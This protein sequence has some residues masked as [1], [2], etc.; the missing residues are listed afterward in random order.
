[1]PE[2]PARPSAF[3]VLGFAAYLACSWTW[4]IGM[5]LPVVL[6]RDFGVWS[7]AVFAAPNIL[8]AAMMGSLL[9]RPGLS[10]AIVQRHPVVLRL[11][12]LVTLA[13]QWYFFGWQ[14]EFPDRP[15]WILWFLVAAVVMLMLL[16]RARDGDN[17]T[18]AV[19][20]LVWLASVGCMVAFL[21]ATR[22]IEPGAAPTDDSRG[23]VALAP[24]CVFGFALCPYLDLTFH[25]AR[26]Q[27]PGRAGSLAFALGFGVLFAVMI[28]FTVLYGLDM[29]RLDPSGRSVLARAP[30]V[31][32]ILL[33]LAFTIRLHAAWL[34]APGPGFA[35]LTRAA[36]IHALLVGIGL[37]YGARMPGD[38]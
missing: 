37:A 12:S 31:I 30:V 32:H 24:V 3:R 5:Y 25:Q 19:S 10:E 33:Q 27:L 23:L 2:G 4:C 13:F 20:L 34:N 6:L 21:F 18:L 38:R 36:P 7:F 22:G 11:F 16:P 29:L 28:L 14:F 17:W 8:G 1:M 15:E 35:S 9:A 26:R